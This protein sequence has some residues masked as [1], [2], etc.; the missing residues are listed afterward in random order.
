MP[1][2]RC[3]NL[4]SRIRDGDGIGYAL[5]DGPVILGVSKDADLVKAYAQLVHENCKSTHLGD[6][7]GQDV[8]CRGSS[9]GKDEVELGEVA[10]QV[11]AEVLHVGA[12]V[13]AVDVVLHI[14]AGRNMCRRAT[15]RV[16]G[17]GVTRQLL[18]R[19]AHNNVAVFA[20]VVVG[21]KGGPLAVTFAQ[22]GDKALE[23]F[24]RGRLLVDYTAAQA[25]DLPVHEDAGL[26]AVCC[27]VLEHP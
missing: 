25:H 18:I 11:V 24:A 20:I 3:H 15:K 17:L 7:G 6:A 23:A 13:V 9:A 8:Q 12:R 4:G 19:Y 14:R 2:R 10:D 22:V 1:A 16:E 21:G 5:D 27:V 26:K